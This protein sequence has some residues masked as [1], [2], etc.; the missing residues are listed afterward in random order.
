MG[1][2]MSVQR[3]FEKFVTEIV[4]L[5]Q[6]EDPL[7]VERKKTLPK[8]EIDLERELEPGLG[9]G[10][11]IQMEGDKIRLPP[12]LEELIEPLLVKTAFDWVFLPYLLHLPELAQQF[13]FLTP[14]FFLKKTGNKLKKNY[15]RI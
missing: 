13:S 6:K 10:L 5:L 1:S 12:I 2:S 4:Q 11:G 7:L 15:N 8:V 9:P 3:V 14:W